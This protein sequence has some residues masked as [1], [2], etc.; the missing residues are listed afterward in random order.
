[1]I[2]FIGF[3]MMIYKNTLFLFAVNDK[4]THLYT[5]IIMQPSFLFV[6]YNGF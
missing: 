3:Q 6:A 1:M 2:L 5:D 4:D